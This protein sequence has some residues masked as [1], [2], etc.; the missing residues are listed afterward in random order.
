MTTREGFAAIDGFRLHYLEWGDRSRPHLLLVHGWDG[1]ARY[2]DL[3]APALQRGFHLIA[4]T[5]RGR[6]L[7][8]P[9]PTGEYR[10]DGYVEELRAFTRRLGL[11][12]LSW[13]G[14]SLG[15]LIGLRYV[16][17]HPD[18]VDR[19]ALVD[20]GAQLGGNRPSSYYAGM[21][22]A[23]DRF[24]SLGEADAWFR[25]WTLYEKLPTSGMAI[26]LREHLEEAPD[27]SWRWRYMH[28]LRAAQR[29]VPRDVL[30]PPQWAV[31]PQVGCPVLIVHG[32]RSE[33]LLPDV[34]MRTREA[35][36]QATLV[37]ISDC[38]HFPF[39]EAPEALI[40]H[41]AQF[42]EHNGETEC[43]ESEVLGTG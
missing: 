5:L 19:L 1:T 35:L 21:L 32:T 42:L 26:V 41:L 16:A 13:V 22:D 40:A 23:P 9:D 37:Q 17:R 14:A 6:G 18:Q 28:K 34:A 38:S 39:L 4:V 33:S 11:E 31:L 10:F 2:W 8:D 24:T 43:P 30:F 12:R 20:I 27:A 29:R 7:S 15:G 36:P 3:V 25:Q